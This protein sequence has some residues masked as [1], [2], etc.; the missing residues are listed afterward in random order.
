MLAVLLSSL[1]TAQE[2]TLARITSAEGLV[3]VQSLGQSNWSRV[4]TGDTVN[5]GD[6]LWADQNSR[7]ELHIGSTVIRVNS[8]T[9]ITLET[10]DEPRLKLWLG[11]VRLHLMRPGDAAVRIETPNLMLGLG[12]PG[13]YRIDVNGPGDET[14]ATVFAGSAEATAVDAKYK[15]EAA[16]S[17]RLSGIDHLQI[18]SFPVPD[19]DDFDNWALNR[20][21][22]Q[23]PVAVVNTSARS[24]DSTQGKDKSKT[25]S[26]GSD[27]EDAGRDDSR[28]V[29]HRCPTP[30]CEW[31][32]YPDIW[33]AVLAGGF[34]LPQNLPPETFPSSVTPEGVLRSNR[35]VVQPSRTAEGQAELAPLKATQP[36]RAR[37]ETT[38]TSTTERAEE[39]PEKPSSTPMADR[40][41]P[42][43]SASHR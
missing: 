14:I 12:N 29:S 2:G 23:S 13:E 32:A 39:R 4:V 18:N 8:E 16:Q 36:I 20:D 22:Q 10:L 15:V 24:G 28:Y 25:A 5:P 34:T 42:A 41:Q 40:H 11:A 21:K 26:N 19:P 31:D 7:A 17:A 33:A 30:W 43:P 38:V 35:I 37:Q 27:H 9:S 1:A 6:S 3:S